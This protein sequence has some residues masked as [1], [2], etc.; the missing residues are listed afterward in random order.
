MQG[1]RHIPP[2]GSLFADPDPPPADEGRPR[3]TS[4]G[5]T[6]IDYKD[7]TGILTKPK[8]FMEGYDFTINPYSGCAFG[9]AYCYAAAFAPDERSS[10]EWGTWVRVKQNAIDL[11]R[12]GKRDVRGKS[13]YISSVTDPY[14]PIEKA[15]ELTRGI[16]AELVHHQPRLVI[17]T[18]SPLVAR[19]LDLLKQ[20]KVAQV[21]MTVTT[22]SEEV[23]RAF[24][25]GCPGNAQRL[26]AIAKVAA[27]G[28]Q[29]CITMTPLLPVEN[30]QA[31]ADAL[32]ATGVR[33]F[34]VQPFHAKKGQYAAGTRETAR[35]LIE[36]YAWD[37]DGY[38]KVRAVLRARLPN[39]GEGKEG[40]GPV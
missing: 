30:A 18:R 40:F 39:L 8:G 31:F 32:L 27:A 24:E 14:Q 37:G 21:N 17:Q 16:L 7:A 34:I 3:P 38:E 5:L 9:C 6:V 11:L 10:Q 25:P 28:I 35:P 13:I 26:D 23:R 1:D 36:R 2:T 22:D 19:D 29:T 33:R 20:F 4:L 12:R 15:L